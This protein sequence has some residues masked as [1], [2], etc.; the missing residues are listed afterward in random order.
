MVQFSN[1]VYQLSF[2]NIFILGTVRKFKI[3]S[4]VC[5]YFKMEKI[6]LPHSRADLLPQMPHP[7]KD[8]VVKCPTNTPGGG[9]G[10]GGMRVVGIDRAISTSFEVQCTAHHELDFLLLFNFVWS[11]IFFSVHSVSDFLMG[12]QD[13]VL[14]ESTMSK[15]YSRVRPGVIPSFAM[16]IASL[17]LLL[18]QKN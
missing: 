10:E 8:K 5:M 7:R 3:N 13:M 1:A 17:I 4:E 2:Y 15:Q 14:S 11:C 9:G 18:A 12:E 6:K 16:Q